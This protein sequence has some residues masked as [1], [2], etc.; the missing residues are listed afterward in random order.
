MKLGVFI[1]KER[2]FLIKAGEKLETA[3]DVLW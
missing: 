3:E 2:G 1:K